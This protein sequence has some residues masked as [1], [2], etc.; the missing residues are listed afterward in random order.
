MDARSV[1]ARET[2]ASIPQRPDATREVA[3]KMK[4]RRQFPA[5]GHR[6]LPGRGAGATG[7]KMS[8]GR[9]D[10]EDGRCAQQER[11]ALPPS[12]GVWGSENRSTGSQECAGTRGRSIGSSR[13]DQRPRSRR[14]AFVVL[15]QATKG[16]VAS[17]VFQTKTFQWLRRG[18]G[19]PD[20]HVTQPL[21]GT[22]DIPAGTVPP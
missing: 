4:I 14:L 10:D 20:R 12:N 1:R 21:M 6:H 13:K 5:I 2:L 16:L 15:Q 22:S 19:R 17:N 8:S 7:L 18:Q 9:T 3:A 11:C